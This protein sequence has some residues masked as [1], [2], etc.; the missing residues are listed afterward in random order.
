MTNLLLISVTEYDT[1]AAFLEDVPGLDRYVCF[2]YA[3]KPGIARDLND[4]YA[5]IP[6]VSPRAV[7]LV[8]GFRRT[9]AGSS[10]SSRAGTLP[11]LQAT[12]GGAESSA[13]SEPPRGTGLGREPPP[14]GLPRWPG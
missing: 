6:E 7:P 1:R 12:R 10:R 8:S 2:G 9:R 3:H 14:G 13:G 5:R 11:V 4:F